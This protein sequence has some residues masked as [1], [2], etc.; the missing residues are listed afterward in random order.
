[1]Q[2]QIKPS[3]IITCVQGFFEDVFEKA[4]KIEYKDNQYIVGEDLIYRCYQIADKSQ[5]EL[6]K[7]FDGMSFEGDYVTTIFFFLSGAWEIIN[8]NVK[9]SFR[10][11]P[12]KESFLFKRGVLATP[13]V[14]H[15]LEEIKKSLSLE[16]KQKKPVAYITH[17]IDFLGKTNLKNALGDLLKR[18]NINLAFERVLKSLK[19]RPPFSIENLLAIHSSFSTVG[20]FFFMTEKQPKEYGGGYDSE[21]HRKYLIS[22]SEKIIESGSEIGI[23]YSSRHLESV[24]YLRK[25]ISKLSK[26]FKRPINKGR[27]HFL[28]LDITKSFDIYENSGIIV[29]A[30]G[31]YSD[32]IGFRFGTSRRFRPYNFK[33]RRLYSF[34]EQPLIVMEGTLQNPRYMNL[35]PEKGLEK[36]KQIIDKVYEVNGNFTLLWHNTSF[37]IPEWRDWEFV[38]IETL[39]YLKEKGFEFKTL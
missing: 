34:Y 30:T 20:T 11:F 36:I 5:D 7:D 1:M 25:E 12:G 17:D 28:L 29:D 16:Y 23:H 10:R 31:G 37:F 26:V 2:L 13:M 38:Y 9:D 24:D 22:L 15:I 35:T 14:D 33:E 4:P 8:Q 6:L 18:R 39:K 3:D 19:G 21:K 27:A 32:Q